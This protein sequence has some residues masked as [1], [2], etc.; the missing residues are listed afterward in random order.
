MYVECT[1]CRYS[2]AQ[3]L[4]SGLVWSDGREKGGGRRRERERVGEEER[5]GKEGK[6]GRVER[7]REREVR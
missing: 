3:V 4:Y 6:G 5:G 7:G 1:L 2:N